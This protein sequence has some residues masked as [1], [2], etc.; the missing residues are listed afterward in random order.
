MGADLPRLLESSPAKRP[1]R[2]IF[3]RSAGQV[4]FVIRGG[5]GSRAAQRDDMRTSWI[6][7]GGNFQRGAAPFSCQRLKSNRID[8]TARRRERCATRGSRANREVTGIRAAEGCAQSDRYSL[9]VG[10]CYRLRRALSTHPERAESQ[11]RGQHQDLVAGAGETHGL[12]AACGIV[13]Y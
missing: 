2:L 7:A 1:A 9:V 11:A 3:S 6:R 8:T 13:T 12:R 5:L 10:D 4:S